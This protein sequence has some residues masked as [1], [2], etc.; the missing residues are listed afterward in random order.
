M[1]MSA[2]LK[3]EGMALRSEL[4]M[5]FM[6]SSLDIILRGLRA[7]SALKPLRKGKLF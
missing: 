1:L 7:L 5:V 2:T 6:P 4:T 3:R